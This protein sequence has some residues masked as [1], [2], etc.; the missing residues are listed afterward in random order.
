MACGLL[1]VINHYPTEDLRC[2]VNV[3][4]CGLLFPLAPL[5]VHGYCRAVVPRLRLLMPSRS[6]PVR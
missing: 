3:V 2:R 6:V 4:L 1:T 5:L